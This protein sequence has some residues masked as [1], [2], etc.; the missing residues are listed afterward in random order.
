MIK[1]HVFDWL[2]E[3]SLCEKEILAKKWLEGFFQF[4][5]LNDEK[6]QND[7]WWKKHTLSC[8]YCNKRYIC[9]GASRLG[10]VWLRNVKSEN[11]YD[12]RV[13]LTKLRN[14]RVVPKTKC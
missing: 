13:C 10:D 12:K 4:D 6:Y 5:H 2:E 11:F 7:L 8:E 14:W 3:E 9:T 1:K